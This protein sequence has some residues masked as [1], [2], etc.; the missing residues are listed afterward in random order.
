MMNDLALLTTEAH[1]LRREANAQLDMQIRQTLEDAAE[2][3][4]ILAKRMERETVAM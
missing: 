4:E 2:R 3:L 1:R